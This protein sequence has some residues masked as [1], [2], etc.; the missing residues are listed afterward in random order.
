MT[1]VCPV[2]VT[3]V[4]PVCV[5]CVCD[6][7]VTCVCVLCVCPMCFLYACVCVYAKGGNNLPDSIGGSIPCGPM[8]QQETD[9]AL[10]TDQLLF[11]TAVLGEDEEL[12]L[13]GP[14]MA[15]L[16]VS[17]DAIDTDFMVKI[18][19]VYPTGEVRILQDNA[20][21]MRWREGGLEP[22]YMAK[23][24]VYEV[25]MNLSNTSYVVAPGH[26]LRIAISSSNFP[27]FSVNPNNGLLLADPTY[28]GENVTASNTLFHS[29]QYPSRV[30]LPVIADKSAQLPDVDVLKE[31]REAY[32]QITDNMLSKFDAYLRSRRF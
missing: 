19:D 25:T 7:C 31:M 28:P 27:R 9:N 3:C 30:S 20:A 16:F 17:S 22:V 5:T 11:Q 14:I 4:C 21:R 12:A 23:G 2:C 29:A 13:T 10:R 6:L 15:T 8:D 1:C 32:P 18:S 24:E 26:A